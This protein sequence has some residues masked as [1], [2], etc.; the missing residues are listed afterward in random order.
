MPMI[1]RYPNRKLYDTAAKRYVT[2]EGIADLVRRGEDVQV[3]DYETGDDLT[4]IILAQIILEEARQKSG[5]LPRAL[6]TGLIRTG[7]DTL[8]YLRR[9]FY[10]SL[11]VVRL[12][13]EEVSRR[14]AALVERGELSQEEAQR[15]REELL[16]SPAEPYKDMAAGLLDRKLDGLLQRLNVPTRA[17]VDRLQNQLEE[18]NRR[19]EALLGADVKDPATS[20]SERRH[21]DNRPVPTLAKS[22]TDSGSPSTTPDPDRDEK[23][24]GP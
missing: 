2:L 22:A 4:A 5:L 18:L 15:L 17:D 19:L 11:G 9:S 7:G 16:A 20:Q 14:L 3:V 13:E 24:V 1:R 23:K 21:A 8:H 10:T 6:L 12:F